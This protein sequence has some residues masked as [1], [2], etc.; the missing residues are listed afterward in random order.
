MMSR[1]LPDSKGLTVGVAAD[2]VI[3][4]RKIDEHRPDVILLDLELPRIDG[5]SFLKH[6]M[7]KDPI[8][9]VICS[10][11]AELGTKLALEALAEGAF[12][13]L[14]K[15]KRG[16]TEF[17]ERSAAEFRTIL[18][19]AASSAPR[20]S[21]AAKTAPIRP[22]PKLR[23][24]SR[25]VG[26]ACSRRFGVV[27]IGTSTG[28]PQALH[29]VLGELSPG[30]PGLV[31]V[32][33]MPPNFTAALARRL[34]GECEIT[35]R[36]ASHGDMV[37]PGTALISPGD[38]HLM[39]VRSGPRFSVALADGPN[40]NGHKPSVDVLFKSVARAAGSRACGVILTGMGSD[41]AR[42]LM[43]MRKVGAYTLGESEAS[44]AVYGMPQ[45]AFEMG[46]IDRVV[47]RCE[48]AQAIENSGEEPVDVS[49]RSN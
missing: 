25:R 11:I 21:V 24:V 19:A 49:Q 43:K 20:N 47:D 27:A 22:L 15:P 36:E 34:D 26:Q 41:G 13:V 35:V 45:R 7:A 16:V 33:H 18:R 48:I 29:E 17:I 37:C 38:R 23:P 6:L 10:G 39:L 40:V 4:I 1:V 5:L 42:G 30:C 31:I 3:A 44:C 28:G 2:P 32:Q 9:V 8:P 12:D 46:A 14:I